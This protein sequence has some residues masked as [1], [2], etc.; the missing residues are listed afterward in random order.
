MVSGRGAYVDVGLA[1]KTGIG[2]DGRRHDALLPGVYPRGALVRVQLVRAGEQPR[3]R[4]VPVCRACQGAG[5]MQA[6]ACC[7]KRVRAAAVAS[8]G[9][10]KVGG[11]RDL[12]SYFP[13]AAGSKD[14][15]AVKAAVKAAHSAAEAAAAMLARS[16][17]FA[18]KAAKAVK[19]AKIGR[20]SCRERV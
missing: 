11:C 4:Y 12:A 14:C 10:S 9:G 13:S 16:V 7:P 1:G 8:G 17:V 2:R 3:V 15:K 5:H 18:P 6:D 19:A 20:A